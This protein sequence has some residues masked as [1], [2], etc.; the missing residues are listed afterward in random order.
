MKKRIVTT[1]FGRYRFDYRIVG[2]IRLGQDST[3][4]FH[5][6]LSPPF[7]QR[8]MIIIMLRMGRDP[9]RWKDQTISLGRNRIVTKAWGLANN[10]GQGVVL[11]T[12]TAEVWDYYLL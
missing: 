8:D 10:S 4:L 9:R 3:V 5:M 1:W 7:P 2:I 12:D 6:N 11:E